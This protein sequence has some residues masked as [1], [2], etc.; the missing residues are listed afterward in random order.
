MRVGFLNNQVDNRGTGNALY[1]YAHFNETILNN[2]SIIIDGQQSVRDYGMAQKLFSRFGKIYTLWDLVTGKVDIDILY[3]IKSGENDGLLKIDI[4]YVVHAVFNGSQPHGDRYAT[5]SRWMGDKFNIPY[6]PHIIKTPETPTLSIR[7][8]LHIPE[9]ATVFGRHGGM[10]S[11]DISWAWS[12]IDTALFERKN[13]Y[14]IFLNT[15]RPPMTFCDPD[16][17]FFLPATSE[18]NMKS[19]FIQGCDAMIHARSRGETFGI[20]VGEFAVAGLPVITYGQSGERAH[21]EMLADSAYLYNDE[22][23]LTNMLTG[24]NRNTFSPGKTDYHNCTPTNI[25]SK[26]KEV[27]L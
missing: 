13:A 10:D 18:D 9:A 23:E 8:L 12:S 16:R 25:M 24:F 5:V 4:P 7:K 26:F 21:I 11:F 27:F 17:V 14:F 22:S 3:H 2:Q 1:D 15:Y 19:A 20:A 6:V